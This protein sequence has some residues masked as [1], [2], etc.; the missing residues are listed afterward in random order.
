[1]PECL[2]MHENSLPP[3]RLALNLCYLPH[4]PALSAFPDG[5]WWLGSSSAVDA[6]RR[7]LLLLALAAFLAGIEGRVVFY[8]LGQF[9][10]L[11]APWR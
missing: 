8:S 10:R 4:L 3:I 7:L 5:L 9:I 6:L 1:M 2:S 11:T